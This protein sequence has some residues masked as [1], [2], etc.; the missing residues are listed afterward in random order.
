[1][2]WPF[3]P[4]HVTRIALDPPAPA[5]DRQ[6]LAMLLIVKNEARH[7]AQWARFHRLAGA[8]HFFVYDN[9]ST[10]GTM[11]ALRACLPADALTILPWAQ[12]LK[13]PLRRAEV[14]NQV[15]AYAHA[16]ANHGAQF[17]WFAATDADEFL[18]PPPRQTLLDV[19]A[20]HEDKA[21]LF[22]P[23]HNFGRGGHVD[24]PPGGV[25]ENYL[26]RCRDP[27]VP[28]GQLR[29]KCVFDPCQIREISVHEMV[30][31]EGAGRARLDPAEIQ[32][33]HYY[34]RSD[35]E[36]RAKLAR[37]PNVKSRMRRHE[38]RVMRR[39]AQIEADVVQDRRALDWLESMGYAG[40]LSALALGA[41]AS[42]P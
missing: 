12:R 2:I 33:N 14:H 5:P 34:T 35:A 13:D 3:P 30:A 22:L 20:H 21:V 41:G 7:I 36:L 17:R 6:G 16:V 26:L 42:L 31:V 9:G 4:R 15:L 27:F 23:W 32:L 19:L 18:V 39:V 10:D 1:M 29:E 37:G 24:I 11:D 28:K 8:R 40:D 25:L 38:I